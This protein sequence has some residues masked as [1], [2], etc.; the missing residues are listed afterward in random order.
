[1]IIHCKQRNF[2]KKQNIFNEIK[3]EKTKLIKNEFIN[4]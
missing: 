2:D 1:M 4:K 3:F